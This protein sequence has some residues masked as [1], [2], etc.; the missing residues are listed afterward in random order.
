[1]LPNGLDWVLAFWGA[2]LAG[3]VA[4]P[5]NTRFKEPEVQYVVSDSGARHVFRPRDALPDGEPAVVE[6]LSEDCGGV[7][8][9]LDQSLKLGLGVRT[10]SRSPRRRAFRVVFGSV[11]PRTSERRDRAA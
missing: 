3:A 7:H 9:M 6:D 11:M 4:V 10:S 5:V 1:M 2:Q 8:E